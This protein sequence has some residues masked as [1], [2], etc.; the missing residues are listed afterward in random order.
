MDAGLGRAG[1][2]RRA[3]PGRVGSRVPSAGEVRA[4]SSLR[5]APPPQQQVQQQPGASSPCGWRS[6]HAAEQMRSL[7]QELLAEGARDDDDGER[8]RVAA[9]L[10]AHADV[11]VGLVETDAA[12]P[13][14][15]G[16]PDFFKVV[17]EAGN[18]A[19][20]GYYCA[21]HIRVRCSQL[22]FVFWR[23]QADFQRFSGVDDFTI[24]CHRAISD[25]HH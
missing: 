9:D 12:A 21:S 1:A 25:A 8:V 2:G 13:S 15:K 14:I 3:A 24:D 23:E 10:A 6:V 11:G 4:Q 16:A 22:E 17:A 5:C 18:D 7:A 20:S 19:R